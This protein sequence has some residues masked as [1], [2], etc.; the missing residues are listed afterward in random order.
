MI[1]RYFYPK[2]NFFDKTFF[3]YDTN[4]SY[5]IDNS[6]FL[7]RSKDELTN[8]IKKIEYKKKNNQKLSINFKKMILFH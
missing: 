4:N 1:R 6:I 8:Y 5:S 2:D 3:D 7:H